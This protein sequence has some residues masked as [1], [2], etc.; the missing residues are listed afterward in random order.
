MNRHKRK[1]EKL[2][3]GLWVGRI[4]RPQRL[5]ADPNV[6]ERFDKFYY[7]IRKQGLDTQHRAMPDYITDEKA[8]RE[9]GRL[10]FQAAELRATEE[11]RT[12]V[13]HA[14]SRRTK[15][16]TVGQYLEALEKVAR[17]RRLK[18][19]RRSA[20]SLRLV[21]AVARG[22]LTKGQRIDR[23][24][25]RIGKDVDALT[26][27][28]AIIAD[29]AYEY[30]RLTQE[31][32][33]LNL[34]RNNPPL[35]NGTINSTLGQARGCFSDENRIFEIQE[36]NVPWQSFEGFMKFTLPEA[37]TD[38]AADIPTADAFGKMM[39][40]WQAD[41]ASADLA[42]Q[43]RAL[44]NEMLRLLGLRSGELV[45]ARESWLWV[46]TDKRNYLWVQNYPSEGWSCKTTNHAK[47]PL[48]DD[49]AARLR[50]RGAAARA[51]GIQNP[52][53]IYP[54]VP[55]QPV[56]PGTGAAL[57]TSARNEVIRYDHNAWLKGFIG[58][59]RSNQGNHR[60]RKYCATRIYLEEMAS[61]GN[62]SKA[63]TR[64]KEYLRHSKEATS[65]LH[66]IAKNDERLQTVTDA[67]LHQDV[68]A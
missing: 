6:P 47:L 50:A 9:H 16:V 29:T 35:V 15:S 13:H 60:L 14:L 36:L 65:L 62:E 34:D 3:R 19:W 61:H 21:I 45:M 1:S 63:A 31:G 54:M 68:A 57:E 18:Q 28:D 64:V 20:S 43:E 12:S 24:G 33:V 8:A 42:R 48:T 41:V 59:V 5:W 23:E 51:A 49:L 52:H 25:G 32:K 58:E 39:L 2:P 4:L 44:V 66:Y 46:G 27:R 56:D 17:R 30:A 38:V 10:Q 53:L 22:W 7:R 40:A 55:G 67:T 11:L 37:P 26:L